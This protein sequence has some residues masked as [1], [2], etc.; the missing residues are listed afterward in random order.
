MEFYTSQSKVKLSPGSLR[1]ITAFPSR[2]KQNKTN[3]YGKP[4]TFRDTANFTVLHCLFQNTF[5]MYFSL[6]MNTSTQSASPRQ[7]SN[8]YHVIIT[9]VLH[10][11]HLE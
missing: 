3:T 11:V 7:L 1:Q 9:R 10:R 5:S 8:G 2:T 4:T 6:N